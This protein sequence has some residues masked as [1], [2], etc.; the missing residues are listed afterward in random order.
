MVLLSRT[1][2]PPDRNTAV[3]QRLQNRVVV[4]P[5]PLADRGAREPLVVELGGDRDLVAGHLSGCVNS[6]FGEDAC[7]CRSGDLELSGNDSD[8]A[9]SEVMSNEEFRFV[10]S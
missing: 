2:C 5:Q 10:R 7:D 3:S 9:D 4:E 6:V 1:G 8:V